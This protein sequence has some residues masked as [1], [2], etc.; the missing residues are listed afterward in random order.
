M[1]GALFV[2]AYIGSERYGIRELQIVTGQVTLI[3]Q[4]ID[5]LTLPSHRRWDG[6]SIAP[7]WSPE[8]HVNQPIDQ[9]GIAWSTALPYPE[10][11]ATGRPILRSYRSAHRIA[12]I[13]PERRSPIH[14]PDRT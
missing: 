8:I 4:V 12:F 14:D 3:E 1:G 2:A 11:H 6:S 13:N 9:S 7:P 10:H 5:R